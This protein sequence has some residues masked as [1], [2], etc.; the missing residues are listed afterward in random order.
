MIPGRRKEL[1]LIVHL[2]GD[3]CIYKEG[4]REEEAANDVVLAP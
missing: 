2:L 4:P 3:N 1:A